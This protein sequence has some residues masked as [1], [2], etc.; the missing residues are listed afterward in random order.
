MVR[1]WFYE[2]NSY[3]SSYTEKHWNH[4]DNCSLW[5]AEICKN[6]CLT[7]F[8]KIT[9]NTDLSF[10]FFGAVSQRY[11]TSY[12]QA[13]VLILP[14]NKT[15]PNFHMHFLKSTLISFNERL[16]LRTKAEEMGRRYETEKKWNWIWR[17][18][19]VLLRGLFQEKKNLGGQ[20]IVT[21]VTVD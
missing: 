6:M 11:L 1:S 8:T 18:A 19:R 14:P 12:L 13:I 10:C 16:F 20:K 7:A 4:G 17:F 9:Y 5:L 21:S 15:T 3:S 2:L